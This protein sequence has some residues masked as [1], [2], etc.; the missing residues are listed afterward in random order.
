MKAIMYHYI[1]DDHTKNPYKSFLH[2]EDFKR[3]LDFFE[4][5]YG[6]MRKSDFLEGIKNKQ[7]KNSSEVILTFD[8]GTTST[9]VADLNAIGDFEIEK[10]QYSTENSNENIVTSSTENEKGT[11]L[12]AV[13]ANVVSISSENALIKKDVRNANT[14][15]DIYVNNTLYLSINQNGEYEIKNENSTMLKF[16]EKL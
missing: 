12:T 5:N 11:V 2:V 15:F 14:Y 10:I 16:L 1:H 7:F 6:I 13:G 4:T 8:D 3:Q 9:T